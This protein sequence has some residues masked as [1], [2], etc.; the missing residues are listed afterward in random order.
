MEE[1]KEEIGINEIGDISDNLNI[2][3]LDKLEVS[4]EDLNQ[5]EVTRRKD[6]TEADLKEYFK[7][8]DIKRK[9][10]NI[11]RGVKEFVFD[12][13]FVCMS[14]DQINADRK[15]KNYMNK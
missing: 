3:D 2:G 7:L 14:R 10:I 13:G 11:K 6:P 9:E 8:V 12:D 4:P 5:P 15:H 1:I